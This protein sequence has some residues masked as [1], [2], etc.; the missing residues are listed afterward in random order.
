MSGSGVIG[1]EQA[2]LTFDLSQFLHEA[3]APLGTDGTAD[4]V[5]LREGG[6]YVMYLK[7]GLL[8]GQLPD[9]KQWVKLDFSKVG[10]AAGIDFSKLMGGQ[11]AQD[12]AQLLSLLRATSGKVDDLGTE[13]IDGVHTTH[14][15]AVIDVAKAGK[16]RGLSDASVQRLLGAGAPAYVPVDVWVG[17]DGLVR[18]FRLSLE[19]TANGTPLNMR[20][21]IGLSNYGLAASVTAPPAGDVFD[22]TDLA[23]RKSG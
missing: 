8:A 19:T 17:A 22:A 3:G 9:G 21:T 6:D 4:E 15:R 16:L 1:P 10:R 7:L 20:M 14:Y 2:E 11:T 23:S 13:Q 5:F 12:P 18:R